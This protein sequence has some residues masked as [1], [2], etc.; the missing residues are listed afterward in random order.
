MSI[1]RFEASTPT[2]DISAALMEAGCAVITDVLSTNECEAIRAELAPHLAD[3][4]VI[5]DDDPEEFY[6]GKTRR[7]SAL[8]QHSHLVTD[9]LIPHPHATNICETTLVPN[10]EFGYQLHVS[11]ALEVGPGAR[12]QILHAKKI[13]L[14]TFL[15][16]A[17]T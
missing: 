7:A 4:R 8:V 15:S 17:L 3:A 1:P 16:H 2:E 5:E 12:E 13:L 11:A 9:Q 6:P 10:S 14:P